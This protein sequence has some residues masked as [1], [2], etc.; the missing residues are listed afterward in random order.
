MSKSIS[1]LRRLTTIGLVVAA[2][3]SVAPGAAQA[4]T[5]EA[6]TESAVT[7]PTTPAG[8]LRPLSFCAGPDAPEYGR[9]VS[10]AA[11]P[12]LFKSI[13]LRDCQ[14][15]QN[16]FG[17]VCSIIVGAGWT[18]KPTRVCEPGCPS[19]AWSKPQTRR[20]GQIY[21]RYSSALVEQEFFAKVDDA[22]P[23]VLHVKLKTDRALG[24]D[25]TRHL[26]FRRA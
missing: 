19:I 18:L 8:T 26:S 3:F 24:R 20:D 10:T 21:A 6:G 7:A 12:E 16:C 9:W 25:Q 11:E 4:A 17:D 22:D 23:A 2:M 13:E 1:R 15:I 14:N 5:V